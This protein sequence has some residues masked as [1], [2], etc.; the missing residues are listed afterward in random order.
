MRLRRRPAAAARKRNRLKYS[1]QTAPQCATVRYLAPMRDARESE[2]P[3]PRRLPPAHA[4]SHVHRPAHRDGPAGAGGPP[5]GAGRPKGR[6]FDSLGR[7]AAPCRFLSPLNGSLV[8]WMLR[9]GYALAEAPGSRLLRRSAHTE[10]RPDV[11]AAQVALSHARWPGLLFPRRLTRIGRGLR[12][13]EHT[14]NSS[15]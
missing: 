10:D 2:A 12:S 1:Q 4:G 14:L 15:N 6:R 11:F 9:A 5:S 8:W 7:R 13:E 3:Y